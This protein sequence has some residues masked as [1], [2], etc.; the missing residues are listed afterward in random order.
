MTP[1]EQDRIETAVCVSE[2]A[3]SG[4]ASG[5][6]PC[7][8][9]TAKNEKVRRLISALEDLEPLPRVHVTPIDETADE[10][11]DWHAEQAR[12][13][14][15]PVSHE[16]E[17]PDSGNEHR[18]CVPH[19]HADPSHDPEA[20]FTTAV[21]QPDLVNLHRDEHGNVIENY[22]MCGCLNSSRVR[23]VLESVLLGRRFTGGLSESV[24]DE[25]MDRLTNVQEGAL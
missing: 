12:S 23:T 18:Y 15:P 7:E 1:A 3:G 21:Q 14:N 19:D 17:L 24:I 9:H 6:M 20:R 22:H 10:W 5:D 2:I 4:H 11:A 13:T 16:V 25:V 8:W